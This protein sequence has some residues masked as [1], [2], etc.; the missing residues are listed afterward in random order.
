LVKTEV[1]RDPGL[2]DF[3][4][5]PEEFLRVLDDELDDLSLR[6]T[7]RKGPAQE[8]GQTLPGQPAGFRVRGIAR[9]ESMAPQIIEADGQRS[10]DRGRLRF[11]L[12]NLLGVR[13]R[14]KEFVRWKQWFVRI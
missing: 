14:E 13:L 9:L 7:E 4:V 5:R 10:G 2:V 8:G 11:V 3:P 12:N 6:R 1:H